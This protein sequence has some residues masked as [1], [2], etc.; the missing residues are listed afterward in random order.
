[1]RD[2]QYLAL[3]TKRIRSEMDRLFHGCGW[4]HFARCNQ[5]RAFTPDD[6]YV[7]TFEHLRHH[8]STLLAWRIAIAPGIVQDKLDI[9]RVSHRPQKTLLTDSIPGTFFTARWDDDE[10][11]WA[12]DRFW[13]EKEVRW[14]PAGL[15]KI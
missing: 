7:G 15:I 12:D 6:D 13:G 5:T 1:M 2:D 10:A 4:D 11:S 8:K 9:R 14:C 3:G